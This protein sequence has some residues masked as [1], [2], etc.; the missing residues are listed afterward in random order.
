MAHYNVVL[1]TYFLPQLPQ[2]VGVGPQSCQACS[3]LFSGFGGTTKQVAPTPCLFQT[4]WGGDAIRAEIYLTSHGGSAGDRVAEIS[5]PETVLKVGGPENSDV[6]YRSAFKVAA[7]P[8][9][10]PVCRPQSVIC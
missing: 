8:L 9:M 4:L 6:L 2:K 7:L 5:D 1:F 3:G 10:K